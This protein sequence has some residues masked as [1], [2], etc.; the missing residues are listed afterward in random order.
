MA[1]SKSLSKKALMESNMVRLEERINFLEDELEL[2][3]MAFGKIAI[4]I[5]QRKKIERD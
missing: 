3:K 2:L 4:P 1:N 5:K